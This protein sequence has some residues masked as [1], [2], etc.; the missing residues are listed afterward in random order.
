MA[1]TTSKDNSGRK[2][3]LDDFTLQTIRRR[4]HQ[5]YAEKVIPTLRKLHASL[6]EEIEDFPFSKETLRK[7]VKKLDL[8]LKNP[9]MTGNLSVKGLILF[10]S[11]INDIFAQ[12]FKR[13]RL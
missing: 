6:S 11:R 7:A 4:V 1:I 13:R 8:H 10:Y 3:I 5:F 9:L 12:K 2:V